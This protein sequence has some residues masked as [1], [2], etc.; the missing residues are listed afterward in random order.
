MA[1]YEIQGYEFNLVPRTKANIDSVQSIIEDNEEK[2]RKMIQFVQDLAEDKDDPTDLDT[3]EA[4]AK[5]KEELGYAEVMNQ[6]ELRRAIFKEAL[7]G[8]TDQLD[9][10]QVTWDQLEEV[11]TD[12][13]PP[14]MRYLDVLDAS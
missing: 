12:F 8:P 7:S 5:A 3:D 2:R 9:M 4:E 10:E 1:D 6:W 11:R 13:L 14:S